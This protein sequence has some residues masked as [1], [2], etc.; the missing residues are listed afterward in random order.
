MRARLG[1]EMGPQVEA[2]RMPTGKSEREVFIANLLFRIHSI[3]EMIWWTG[4]APWEYV[5]FLP[6]SCVSTFLRR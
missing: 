6:G 5:F 2:S 1:T 3:I 4:L